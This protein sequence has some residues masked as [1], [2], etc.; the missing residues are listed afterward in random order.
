MNAYELARS[1]GIPLTD[2]QLPA[3]FRAGLFRLGSLTIAG[4]QAAT[5]QSPVSLLDFKLGITT[6]PNLFQVGA[7]GSNAQVKLGIAGAVA[8][9]SGGAADALDTGQLESLAA[10]L[11]IQLNN[12]AG[13]LFFP[14]RRPGLSG[15]VQRTNAVAADTVSPGDRFETAVWPW[16]AVGDLSQSTTFGLAT[17]GYS[18]G[19][20]PIQ[21]DL[22]AF[23]AAWKANENM[24][25]CNL[26]PAQVRADLLSGRALAGVM[27]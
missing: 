22:Y 15:V 11:Y 25:G 23:G 2:G 27:R 13:P 20:Q 12:G 9:I 26:P 5:A 17:T 4:T 14:L 10:S 7:S 6:D 1:L 24:D 21:L 16:P 8:R 3:S 18:A 19:L